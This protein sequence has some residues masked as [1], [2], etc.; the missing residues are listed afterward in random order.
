[1]PR[2][3]LSEYNTGSYTVHE[4]PHDMLPSVLVSDSLIC[5]FH[6]YNIGHFSVSVKGQCAV[7]RV[8]VRGLTYQRFD[9]RLHA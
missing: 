3:L 6:S 4:S 9:D 2:V 7:L 1:M 8:S 5:V